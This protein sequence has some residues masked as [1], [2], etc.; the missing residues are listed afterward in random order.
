MSEPGLS[1]SDA[2]SEAPSDAARDDVPRCSAKGCRAP[3]TTDLHWRNPRL[4]DE[5]RVKHW[6]ACA[7]HADSLAD[8]LA[9]RGFMLGRGGLPANPA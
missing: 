7:E 5:A 2:P 9:R 1:P 6:L 3:A 4:H 8:F